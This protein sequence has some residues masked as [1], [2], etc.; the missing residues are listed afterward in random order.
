MVDYDETILPGGEGEIN[1]RIN[2]NN[3]GQ[4]TYKKTIRVDTNDPENRIIIL[5]VNA[6]IKELNYPQSRDP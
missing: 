5:T 1:V 3:Y 2:T 4:G 6:S